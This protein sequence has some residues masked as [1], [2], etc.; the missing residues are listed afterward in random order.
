MV[1]EGFGVEL[2][3]SMRETVHFVRASCST[4]P[5]NCGQHCPGN[6]L[7]INRLFREEGH[8]PLDIGRMEELGGI[9]RSFTDEKAL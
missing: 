7:Y 3:I 4:V 8:E 2:F 1:E 5:F 9:S 6:R